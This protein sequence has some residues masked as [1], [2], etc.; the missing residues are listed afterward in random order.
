MNECRCYVACCGG[1]CLI[2]IDVDNLSQADIFWGC[3]SSSPNIFVF[4]RSFSVRVVC[5]AL[6][7]PDGGFIEFFILF[8]ME[9][10]NEKHLYR[11]LLIWRTNTTFS[12]FFYIL[13]WW[14]HV[15]SGFG[16]KE[17]FECECIWVESI[18]FDDQLFKNLF[19]HRNIRLKCKEYSVS[20]K[21]VF[22]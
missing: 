10:H 4:I 19:N 12:F 11:V 22:D 6:I 5:P 15:P 1:W 7:R 3:R 9:R 17:I 20:A 18:S 13:T 2:F 14:N 16:D 8:L 21:I